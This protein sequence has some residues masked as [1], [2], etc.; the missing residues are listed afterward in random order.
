MPGI[1]GIT[2][3]RGVPCVVLNALPAKRKWF[4]RLICS[5]VISGKVVSMVL[6]ISCSAVNFPWTEFS[7]EDRFE[8]ATPKERSRYRQ[9]RPKSQSVEVDSARQHGEHR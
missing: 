5:G 8:L 4:E 2:L 6:V 1:A 7:H 3:E 9:N